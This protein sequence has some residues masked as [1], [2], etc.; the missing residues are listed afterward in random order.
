MDEQKKAELD[1]I[2]A[3]RAGTLGG[4]HVTDGKQFYHANDVAKGDHVAGNLIPAFAR[5]EPAEPWTPTRQ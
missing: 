5:R 3:E 2:A 4:E 1:A